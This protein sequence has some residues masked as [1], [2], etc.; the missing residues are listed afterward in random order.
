MTLALTSPKH[1]DGA[2]LLWLSP[3]PERWDPWK[4]RYASVDLTWREKALS[5]GAWAKIHELATMIVYTVTSSHQQSG[6][7]RDLGQERCNGWSALTICVFQWDE[8]EICRQPE[9]LYARV[10]AC[11]FVNNLSAYVDRP[12]CTVPM[13]LLQCY[14]NC[15]LIIL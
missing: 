7:R 2:L 11:T 1:L 6:L 5:E 10:V 9:V 4:A 14:C 8:M 3:E 12:L 15:L 13:I